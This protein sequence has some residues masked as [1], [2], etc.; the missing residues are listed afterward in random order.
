MPWT[1]QLANPDELRRCIS[2]LVAL[3]TLPAAWR[4]YDMRQI[5]DSIVAAL[6]SM[7]D[8]DFVFIA[9]PSHGNQL[10][11]LIRSDPANRARW[12]CNTCRRLRSRHVSNQNREAAPEY[13]G[14]SGGDCLPAVAGRRRQEKVYNL[15][16][17]NER[18]H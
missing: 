13:R 10:N 7:L 8:A 3:S 2:D 1:E 15:G 16:A 12:R 9:L 14:K 11:E 6:V 17:A 4:N 5:G 18:F